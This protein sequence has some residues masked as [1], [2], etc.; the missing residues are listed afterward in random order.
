[1]LSL[2]LWL[3]F[4]VTL[5]HY[6]YAFLR[7]LVKR[8]IDEH[9][10]TNS[11]GLNLLLFENAVLMLDNSILTWRLNKIL[12]FDQCRV[13]LQFLIMHFPRIVFMGD[14]AVCEKMGPKQWIYHY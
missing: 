1:M 4:A 6:T 5:C 13:K 2:S 3:L 11:Q 7:F 9:K 8:E 10:N 14:I 12:D